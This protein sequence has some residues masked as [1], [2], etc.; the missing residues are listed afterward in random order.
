MAALNDFDDDARAD[1]YADNEDNKAI[2]AFFIVA[3]HDG[4]KWADE[5]RF[6][7][8]LCRALALVRHDAGSLWAVQAN[9]VDL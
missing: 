3:Q 5:F 4:F 8:D 2:D 1:R 7:K 9:I 6:V